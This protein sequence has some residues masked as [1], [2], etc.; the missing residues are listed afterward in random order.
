MELKTPTPLKSEHQALNAEINQIPKRPE[1]VE[2]FQTQGVKPIGGTPEAFSV[3]L[4]TQMTKWAKVVKES[5][6]K[7]E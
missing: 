1:I 7:A 5:G 2:L 4:R 6:A 3:Y